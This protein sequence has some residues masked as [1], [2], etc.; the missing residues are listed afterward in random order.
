MAARAVSAPATPASIPRT[1]RTANGKKKAAQTP[2]AL[3][4]GL[5][6]T[7][8]PE[9]TFTPVPTFNPAVAPKP[10]ASAAST[11]QRPPEIYPKKS[12]LRI[13]ATLPPPVPPLDQ[14][15]VSN[16]P[17]EVHPYTAANRAG[18]VTA[19][20]P[21]EYFD[22]A[23]YAET[24]VYTANTPPPAL[25]QPNTLV[26]G[27]LPQR[28]LPIPATDPYAAIGV[29]AG[30]FLLLPSLDLTGGYITNPERI[31]GGPGSGYLVAAPELKVQS[32]WDTPFADRRHR[33]LVYPVPRGPGAFAQRPVSQFQG[34]R[35]HR[36][37]PRHPDQS[38]AAL[39][40]QHRQSGQP[41]PANRARQAADQQ[42][43]VA[44][45]SASPNSSTGWRFRSTAR[46]IAPPT[47]LPW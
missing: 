5:S 15:P 17:A 36:R 19:V 6:I 24:L 2:V 27:T 18:A 11:I 20:P 23:T 43:L 1:P 47:T 9:T 40:G 25:P 28:P 35:T 33:R 46:S 16:P 34:R 37:H 39:P 14:V 42:R 8:Q 12:A 7:P 30:S 44:G 22:Y 31:S 26:P 4:P 21:P 38:R 13:G 45:R 29:R 10:P 3:A 32:D 41:E